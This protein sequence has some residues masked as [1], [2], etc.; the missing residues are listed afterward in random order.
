M[1]TQC[2]GLLSAKY[3]EGEVLHFWMVL[4]V[5]ISRGKNDHDV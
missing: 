1:D 3:K 4:C 5:G 2:V